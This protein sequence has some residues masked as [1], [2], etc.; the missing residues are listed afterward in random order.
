MEPPVQPH[1]T[2]CCNS[3]CNPC[4]LDVYE[5]Q[6]KKYSEY[7]RK[8]DNSEGRGVEIIN[9]I[10][11]TVYTVFKLI[12][13]KRVSNTTFLLKFEYADAKDKTP[14]CLNYKSGQYFLLKAKDCNGEFTRAYTPIPVQND[15][16][17]V[18]TILIR[19]YDW[20]RMSKLL[21]RLQIGHK[22]SWRGPYGDFSITYDYKHLFFIA[23]GTGIAPIFSVIDE[24]VRDEDCECFIKLFYCC[25]DCEDILLRE[26]LYK[27]GGYWNFSYEVFLGTTTNL[28]KKY[29]ETVH[30]TKLNFLNIKNHI[31]GKTGKLQ[32]VICGSDNFSNNI[33]SL[34]EKCGVESTHIYVF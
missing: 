8:I 12:D 25:R 32:A 18:F 26:E 24:I 13:R 15:G 20:G 14:N 27:L 6:L 16:G 33:K 17:L 19:L 34:V 11:P 23:Q 2:D 30:E 31:D 7:L 1:E 3:G 5:T 22:T 21:K 4:I 9:S 29:N 10:N 28:V